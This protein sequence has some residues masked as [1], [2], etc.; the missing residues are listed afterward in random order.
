MRARVESL[1][2]AMN[3]SQMQPEDLDDLHDMPPP[4]FCSL[5]SLRYIKSLGGE[6]RLHSATP[7]TNSL[8]DMDMAWDQDPRYPYYQSSGM[9]QA[10]QI[11][12]ENICAYWFQ[13]CLTHLMAWLVILGGLTMKE[14]WLWVIDIHHV[15]AIQVCINHKDHLQ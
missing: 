6:G 14:W 13:T 2:W 7:E 15:R 11:N 8:E 3:A 1:E 12:T 10:V 4:G 9:S 5:H